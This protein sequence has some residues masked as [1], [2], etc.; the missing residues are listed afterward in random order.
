MAI[1][2]FKSG[3]INYIYFAFKVVGKFNEFLYHTKREENSSGKFSDK[4]F[5]K[6]SF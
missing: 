3:T 6:K 5:V 4:L 2:K 1:N